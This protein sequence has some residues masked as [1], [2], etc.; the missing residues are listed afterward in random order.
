MI[1][2]KKKLLLLHSSNDLYGASKI[3]LQ[4]IDLLTK[5]GFD[6]H[7]IIPE[8][9][10]L[11]NFLIKKDIKIEYLELGVLRKKYLNPLGLINRAVAN[12]KAIAFLSNYIKDHSIDLVYTNTSTVISGGIAAK[13]TGVPSLFHIHEIP[14]GNK[15]YEFLSGKIINII[16]NKVLTVSNSVKKHWLKYIDDK[17]IERIYNGIIFSK[18]DSLIKLERDQDDFVITSVARIIPYKGHGYLID[19]ANELIKKSTKFK[20]LIVGDT[21]PSYVSY[22]KSVKQ[23][24]NDLELE[25]QIKFLGF[26]NDI[27]GILKQS[28]LF[29]H[30]A[31]APDPLPTVLFESLHNDLPTVATNL[32][33]AIE[34]LDNGNNGLLI[35]YNDPKKAANLINEYCTNTKLQKKHL[36]NSKKNFKINFSSESFS[37]NILKEVNNLL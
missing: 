29:I 12:I 14:I 21:L 19:V 32:G 28:D 31:I 11:D 2:P 15:L 25:N 6:V 35:P 22:E 9:G 4:L 27:S 16:S 5:N 34:I 3:F 10:M 7:V 8:K 24:V 26:R 23:K 30:P 20:F 13:R 36:E 17:K 18:T 33:G 37:K 1:S